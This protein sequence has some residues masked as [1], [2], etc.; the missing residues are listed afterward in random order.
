MN[1]KLGIT[2][3][4]F[5]IRPIHPPSSRRFQWSTLNII[6]RGRRNNPMRQEGNEDDSQN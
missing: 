4:K 5:Q 6:L 2:V 1:Y 3:Y